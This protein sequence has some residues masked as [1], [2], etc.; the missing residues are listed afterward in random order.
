MKRHLPLA[1]FALAAAVAGV[2]ASDARN[3]P[4]SIAEREA[5]DARAA[6]VAA[7]GLLLRSQILANDDVVAQLVGGKLTLADAA[8]Q[9][10][11]N[12]ARRPGFEEG[13]RGS[14]PGDYRRMLFARYAVRKSR[15]QLEG[16]PNAWAAASARL[17]AELE[18]LAGTPV[19]APAD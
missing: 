6:E 12:S 11:A 3:L 10:E 19:N 5:A 9:L 2:A 16:D 14:H 17:G 18:T 4:A 15:E 13:L 8:K 7:E 1:L